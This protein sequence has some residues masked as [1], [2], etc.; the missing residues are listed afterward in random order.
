MEGTPL[1]PAGTTVE[2]GHR[3]APIRE[4]LVLAAG[5]GVYFGG[6]EVVQG[7]RPAAVRDAEW[8]IRFE[9]WLGVDIERDL[10]DLAVRSELVRDIGNLSYVWLHW[11]LLLLILAVLFV[12]SSAQYR[13]LRDA[14]FV[15]G[16]VALAIFAVFPAA[17]PRFMPGFIGTVSDEARR[18]YLAIPL[19]WSNPYAAFPSFH[20]GWTLIACLALA[21]SLHRRRWAVLAMVPALLVGAS[22]VT[23]GNHYVVDAVAGAAIALT[24]YWWCGRAPRLGPLAHDATS[25]EYDTN[26]VPVQSRP[27]S[28]TSR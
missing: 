23:T 11:P 13:R 27:V 8:I 1:P 12:R 4:L 20:V 21:A 15:S 22:V 17:P 7:S 3:P 24:A 25:Y 5:A 14:M 19:S 18:H 10:Q 2:P 6:R 9:R 16:A 26:S 28:V